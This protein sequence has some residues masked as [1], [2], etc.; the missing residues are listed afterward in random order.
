MLQSLQ[1]V[2]VSPANTNKNRYRTRGTVALRP[3]FEW[4]IAM[5]FWLWVRA[6]G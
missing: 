3:A 1:A 2:A 6:G 5:A 4:A